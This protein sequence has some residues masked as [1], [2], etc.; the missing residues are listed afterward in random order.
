LTAVLSLIVVAAGANQ[1]AKNRRVLADMEDR[2]AAIEALQS[3][4]ARLPSTDELASISQTLPVRYFQYDYHLDT[5]AGGG[6]D[7]SYP[8]GWPASGGWVLWFWRG[9][10]AEYYSSWDR[11]Y[12]LGDQLSWW[13]FCWPGIIGFAIAAGLLVLSRSPL[14][15]GAK[16][17]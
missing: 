12:T 11:H 16:Q 6:A 10:W 17:V 13:A 4:E 5:T 15:R 9:E 7:P 2:V 14:L 3:R 8:Q 1:V